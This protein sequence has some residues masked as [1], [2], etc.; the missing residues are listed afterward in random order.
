[1]VDSHT[2]LA[3]PQIAQVYMCCGCTVYISVVEL[4]R[5][6]KC[7]LPACLLFLSAF[8]KNQTHTWCWLSSKSRR[9]WFAPRGVRCSPNTPFCLCVCVCVSCGDI[10]FAR[11][12]DNSR[13]RVCVCRGEEGAWWCSPTGG[14]CGTCVIV[15]C[16]TWMWLRA[17]ELNF[18]MTK[19]H[20]VTKQFA[21]RLFVRRAFL[22]VVCVA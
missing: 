7:C 16:I 3:P 11:L 20:I 1:M 10:R 22:S 5:N 17:I 9:V 12:F 8:K 19:I 21:V 15:Y 2:A 18:G 13:R 6:V 14:V 4:C